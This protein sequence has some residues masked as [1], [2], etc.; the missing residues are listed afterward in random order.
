MLAHLSC[1]QIW[2]AFTTNKV[3]AI[4][5]RSS[6]VMTCAYSPSGTLVACGG[7]DNL[8]S[9]YKLPSGKESAT[10]QKTV[11]SLFVI[12]SSRGPLLQYAELAQHEGYL[13]CCRFIKDEEVSAVL[14]IRFDPCWLLGTDDRQRFSDTS[15]LSFGIERI[16]FESDPASLH[17][18]TFSVLQSSTHLCLGL[19]HADYHLVR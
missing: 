15:C 12:F 11:R 5:L 14:L 8:C 13:S 3:N 2:N 7:L 16:L 9:V 1:H 6:W 4:P 17:L 19:F 10:Q 18:C